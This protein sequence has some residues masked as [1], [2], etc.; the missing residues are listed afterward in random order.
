MTGFTHTKV[1]LAV[2]RFKHA[3]VGLF[4]TGFTRVKVGLAVIRFIYP[5]R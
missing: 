5:L 1:G 2:A 4:V 3:M